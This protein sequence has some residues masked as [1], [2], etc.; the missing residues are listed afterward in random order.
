MLQLIMNM[1]AG[2]A[3]AGFAHGERREVSPTCSR[4]CAT[5]PA[6]AGRRTTCRAGKKAPASCFRSASVPVTFTRAWQMLRAL[7]YVRF[8]IVAIRMIQ[9]AALFRAVR[10][11][12]AGGNCSVQHP[13]LKDCHAG[14]RV[15]RPGSDE[16]PTKNRQPT[17]VILIDADSAQRFAQISEKTE[18]LSAIPGR[19]ARKCAGP[20]TVSRNCIA[21]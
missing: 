17:L 8:W 20:H 12:K 11:N 15:S 3:A 10:E 13:P 16:S 4:K 18:F 5:T 1:P 9:L 6:T 2:L 21:A 19:G 7:R 14:L